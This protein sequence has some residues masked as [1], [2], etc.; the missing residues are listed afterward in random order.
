MKPYKMKILLYIF[1][2]FIFGVGGRRPKGLRMVYAHVVRA[3]LGCLDLCEP[4]AVCCRWLG[5][6]AGAEDGTLVNEVPTSAM[7]TKSIRPIHL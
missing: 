4:L 6:V 1:H 2:L 5:C 3:T 7:P